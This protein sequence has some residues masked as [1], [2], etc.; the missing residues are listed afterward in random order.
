MRMFWSMAAVLL[1]GSSRGPAYDGAV[2][3]CRA[4]DFA[5]FCISQPVTSQP[6]EVGA[7]AFFPFVNQGGEFVAAATT[8]DLLGTARAAQTAC[9]S[10]EAP[11]LVSF[12]HAGA[13]TDRYAVGDVVVVKS[14]GRHDR[15]TLSDHAGFQPADT[16]AE[17]V[18]VDAVLQQVARAFA[19][20]CRAAGLKVHQDGR[21]VSGDLFIASDDYRDRLA[22]QFSADLVDQ[23]GASF[24]STLHAYQRPGLVIRVVSDRADALAAQEHDAFL[25]PRDHR[26]TLAARALAEALQALDQPPA[27]PLAD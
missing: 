14:V 2:L 23:G 27:A 10:L 6:I 11:R 8:E 5:D 26:L 21:M 20:R 7:Q 24:A 9:G 13:L 3:F 17:E 22:A 16:A 19:E 12:G 1:L 15:G 4:D 25:H 18:D